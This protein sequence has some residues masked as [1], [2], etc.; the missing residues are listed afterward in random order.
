LAPFVEAPI[1]L[2]NVIAPGSF[3][4]NGDGVGDVWAMAFPV[5]KALPS[6]TVTVYRGSVPVRVLNCA[7]TTGMATAVW[8]GRTGSGARLPTGRYTYRVNG[9][10]GDGWLRSSDLRL[11]PITGAIYKAA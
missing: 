1:Y 4:P 9:R 7:N 8:D 3:S 2:G 5:S 6:C 11:V 10:D